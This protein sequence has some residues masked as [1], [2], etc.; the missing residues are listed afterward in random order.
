MMKWVFGG[1]RDKVEQYEEL[2][3]DHSLEGA[4]VADA[5]HDHDDIFD[6]DDSLLFDTPI[7]TDNLGS[8]KALL[9]S[10]ESPQRHAQLN[11]I[12][13]IRKDIEDFDFHITQNELHLKHSRE[14]LDGFKSFVQATDVEMEQIHRL[15]RMNEELTSKVVADD[16]SVSELHRQ[17]EAER[18]SLA[19]IKNRNNE[20]KDVLTA[21]RNEIIS[22]IKRDSK[23][24]EQLEH[25]SRAST[26]RE[27][28]LL[29]VT[30][31]SERLVAENKVLE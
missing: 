2:N 22:L 21:A 16:V 1:D 26:K 8:E 18:A 17:L 30:R 19:A 31:Q 20:Y 14:Q 9:E 24:R 11:L 12:E 29:E 4:A 13:K 23:L 25:Y 5:S 3:Q 15:R 6:E 7:N 27:A 10:I 28:K